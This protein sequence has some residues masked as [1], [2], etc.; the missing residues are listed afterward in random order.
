M[1]QKNQKHFNLNIYVLII[2]KNHLRYYDN[3]CINV[4]ENF[5]KNLV[6]LN[7]VWSNVTI[8]LNSTLVIVMKIAKVTLF[9]RLIPMPV[10]LLQKSQKFPWVMAQTFG[11]TY[12]GGTG[13][14]LKVSGYP[15]PNWTEISILKWKWVFRLHS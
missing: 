7:C 13:P 15:H 9:R 5:D 4:P 14:G 10:F 1:S 6:T 8:S 3:Y 11:G 2:V 12:S